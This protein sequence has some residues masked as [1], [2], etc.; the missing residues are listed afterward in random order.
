MGT[1]RQEAKAVTCYS[2]ARFKHLIQV[3]NTQEVRR[4]TKIK[5]DNAT[6]VASSTEPVKT[7]QK[8]NRC[9]L[10]RIEFLNHV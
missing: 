10:C 1:E 6:S 8:F 7:R 5:F 3:L 9:L 2:Q 4:L